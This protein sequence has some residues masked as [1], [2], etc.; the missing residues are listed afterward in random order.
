MLYLFSFY[1]IVFI[2]LERP[3]DLTKNQ[4][5]GDQTLGGYNSLCTQSVMPEL[6]I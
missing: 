1:I 2:Q 5:S 3:C 6:V 4:L